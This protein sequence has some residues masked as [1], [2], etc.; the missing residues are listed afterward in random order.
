MANIKY[1]LVQPDKIVKSGEAWGVVLPTGEI[2]Q[3]VISG[4]TPSILKTDNGIVRLLDEGGQIIE[5]F[6]ISSGV[7]TVVDDLCIVAGEH[8]LSVND[9]DIATAS[10]YDDE[11]H[12]MVAEGLKALR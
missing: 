4:Q 11:F 1:K 3:T 10:S 2:N 12:Q 9:I 7:A 8:I 5:Q 6:F